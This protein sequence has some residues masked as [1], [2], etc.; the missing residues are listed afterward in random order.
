MISSHILK[1]LVPVFIITAF[2]FLYT[3]LYLLKNSEIFIAGFS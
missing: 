3:S 1:I 2:I